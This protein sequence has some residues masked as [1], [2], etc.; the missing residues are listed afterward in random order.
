MA[1]LY[2]VQEITELFSVSEHT[3]GEWIK[4]GSLRAIDI[5]RT[6]GG[7]ARWRITQEAL[8]AF[9]ESRASQPPAPRA[10]RRPKRDDTVIAFYS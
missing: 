10:K 2:K 7:K 4:N 6:P 5:S 3:V 1:R 8:E 9:Q